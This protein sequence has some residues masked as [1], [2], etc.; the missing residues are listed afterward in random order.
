MIK[1]F[2]RKINADDKVLLFLSSRAF[3]TLSYPITISL[4]IAYLTPEEQGYY[5]TFLTL[6]SFSM[7]LE[8]GLGVILTNFASHEFSNLFWSNHNK[9]KGNEKSILRVHS[10]IK[11]TIYWFLILA[12]VFVISMLG[13][14]NFLFNES[15]PNHNISFVWL[16][17]LI[18]F[19]PGLIV[20]PFL[21][22]LS[23]FERIKEVQIIKLLQISISIICLWIA[24]YFKQGIFALVIQFLVQ[25][26]ISSFYIFFK[27]RK[28]LY[29]S[30]RS[31]NNSFNWSTEILPLQLKTGFAW[32]VTYLGLNLLIPFSF[33]LFGPVVAGQLGMSFKIAQVVSIVCLAWINTRVPQMG[34]MVAQ[35]EYKKFLYFFN[36]TLKSIFLVGIII[37]IFISIFLFASKYLNLESFNGRI[38]PIRMVLILSIGYF[39]ASLSNYLS[40]TIRA[41]KDEKMIIPNFIALIF[42]IITFYLC[43]H[44]NDLNLIVNNFL[45]INCFILF[46]SSLFM[47]KNLFRSKGVL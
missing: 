6:L 1:Y 31:S 2:L 30:M 3:S 5:Y 13:V 16:V 35:N 22:I 41:F 21:S 15:S 28:L 9:L 8:L 14:G 23:G 42:Y 39:F 11:K 40:M 46:P 27:Y 44:F 18:V 12:L 17:F 37:L 38:L 25:N 43:Y 24:L 34:K 26:A 29:D 7:F 32:I 20:G 33:K 47:I 36:K 4:I 19:S 45:I 10:L